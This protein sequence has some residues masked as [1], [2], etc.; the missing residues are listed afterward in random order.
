MSKQAW[1][2]DANNLHLNDLDSKM[3]NEY[4]VTTTEIEKFLENSSDTN[5]LFIVGPKGVGKTLILKAKSQILRETEKS[6]KFIPEDRLCEKF[7]KIAVSLSSEDINKFNNREVWDQ[8]WE[9]SILCLILKRFKIFLPNDISSII[10]NAGD[11]GEI[12]GCF[13]QNRSSIEKV[14]RYVNSELKPLVRHIPGVSQIAIFIDNIDEAFEQ[15]TGYFLKNKESGSLSEKVWINAQN[16]LMQVAKNIFNTFK[17]IKV[18]ASIRSE[19]YVNIQDSTKLQLDDYSTKI[20]YQESDIKKIFINNILATPDENVSNPKAKDI[21]RLTGFYSIPHSFIEN[22]SGNRVEEDLFKF[23]HRH[24]Y[25]RPREIMEMGKKICSIPVSERTP[26]KV[27]EAVNEVSYKLFQQLKTEVIPFFDDDLFYEFCKRIK[28]NVIS[29]EYALEVYK[30]ILDGY[31]FDGVFTYFYRLGL[32]G[33]V[34]TDYN[35]LMFQ[36]FLPVGLHSLST[37]TIPEYKYFVLHPS[38]NNDLKHFHQNDFYNHH[39]IIG[40]DYH[41]K[42]TQNIKKFKHIHF[43]LDRDSLAIII[44]ELNKSKCLCIVQFPAHEW[45]ELENY[46][47]ILLSY[48]TGEKIEF[49]ILGDNTPYNNKKKI[50]NFFDDC[51][52][53][54]LYTS[55]K[56]VICRYLDECST[57]SFSSFPK[58]FLEEI[59]PLNLSNKFIYYQQRVFNKAKL[60]EINTILARHNG[61]C[62]YV[63]IDKFL[64][65]QDFI[66]K[67]DGTL[68]L[69][70]NVENEGSFIC[71]ERPSYT[72][73]PSKVVIRPKN[74]D[75]LEYYINRQNRLLEGVYQIYKIVKQRFNNNNGQSLD[76]IIE[77]FISIQAY[78]IK[79]K[80]NAEVLSSVFNGVSD[81]QIFKELTA[82]GLKNLARTKGLTKSY[83]YYTNLYPAQAAK[84]KTFFPSDMEIYSFIPKSVFL[85]ENLVEI[86]E[87]FELLEVKPMAEYHSVF[88]SYS[89]KDSKFAKKLYSFLRINGVS[90]FLFEEDN[91]HKPLKSMLEK[92]ISNYDKLIFIAS[93]NSL[94]SEG[95]HF[96]LTK[97]RGKHMKNWANGQALISIKLDDYI[98]KVSQN[99][100]P[101]EMQE[102][103]WAN[104]E[105]VKSQNVIDYSQF[106]EFNDHIA[107]QKQVKRLIKDSLQISDISS[108]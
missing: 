15:H 3:L 76:S 28:K 21:S 11:L 80:T 87:L 32:I 5:K 12:L 99:D 19:A 58:N 90:A 39:N 42:P 93:I 94:Q 59:G 55:D 79:E 101:T 40:Y 9:L 62:N 83:S 18:Y 16:S 49:S 13:L 26:E 31:G 35:G 74:Q 66:R 33:F 20:E 97:C 43:G 52:P 70:L 36:K 8:V 30:E 75:E 56:E 102:E 107:L 105:F 108:T 68:R 86:L 37:V 63:L 96:E 69:D 89:F 73:K 45:S 51:E 71:M 60:E 95:C 78:S 24:T 44:P 41:F 91:P 10:G 27:R 50:E 34:D 85:V 72:M 92:E 23:V 7:S 14:Y 53:M 47:K 84:E 98:F 100:L 2:I 54:I 48:N 38:L 6:Y 106:M 67:T 4:I 77:I 29:Y 81:S 88:I 64:Y 57:I 103:Y 22:N 25:Q 17:H 65:S 1:T 104:I 61:I 82:F 46:E